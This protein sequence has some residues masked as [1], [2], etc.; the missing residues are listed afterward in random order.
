M[1]ALLRSVVKKILF[2]NKEPRKFIP[3]HLSPGA[4]QETV[5]L[6]AGTFEIDISQIHCVVCHRP[7]MMAVVLSQKDFNFDFK[8]ARIEIRKMNKIKA[9]V[10]IELR[11]NIPGDG[12][13]VLVFEITDSRCYQL[14]S[15]HQYVLLKRYFLRHKKD[16]Y[17]EGKIYSAMYSFPRRVIVV[18][19]RDNDYVNIFPMDFQC[20]SDSGLHLFGLRTT[21]VTLAKILA[22]KKVLVADTDGANIKHIYALGRNHSAVPP[23]LADLPFRT[24]DSDSFGFPVPAFSSSYAEIEII[25]Y[26]EL[27]THTLMIGKVLNAREFRPQGPLF[28]HVH[29]FEFIDSTY[30][31][32]MD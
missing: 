10:D 11:K 13:H 30:R 9:K 26:E 17:L 18:S 15:V 2:K 22:T 16:S 32:L 4:I 28:H 25:H 21:N 29:F 31:A 14:N 7:F 20:R 27:G 24:I 3:I 6:I 19:Y 12:R 1:K 23:S 5:A 8:S